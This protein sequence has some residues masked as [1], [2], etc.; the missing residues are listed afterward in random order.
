VND[1]EFALLVHRY[2]EGDLSAAERR[3]LTAE[4]LGDADRREQ[5]GRQVRL[6]LEL[7]ALLQ[8]EDAEDARLRASLIVAEDED[9]RD[10][11]VMRGLGKR[12]QIEAFRARAGRTSRSIPIVREQPP[13]PASFNKGW[14]IAAG[15]VVAVLGLAAFLMRGGEDRRPVAD[16]GRSIEEVVAPA[17]APRPG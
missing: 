17:P 8:P 15:A 9:S 7:G 11:R 5:F 4:V 1:Q 6:N 12:L 2:A 14:L 16:G 10:R 3:D 13:A